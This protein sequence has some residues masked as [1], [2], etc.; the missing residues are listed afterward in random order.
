MKRS[1]IFFFIILFSILFT[2]WGVVGSSIDLEDR[3]GMGFFLLLGLTIAIT[4]PFSVLYIMLFGEIG[5]SHESEDTKP[6]T[7]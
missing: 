5:N 2:T 4:V 6:E 3:S 7:I 1:E